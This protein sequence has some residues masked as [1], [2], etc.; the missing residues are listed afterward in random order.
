MTGIFPEGLF[1]REQ[2]GDGVVAG[3]GRGW[4]PHQHPSLVPAPRG[5]MPEPW[6]SAGSLPDGEDVSQAR[7]RPGRILPTASRTIPI[8]G[9]GRGQ[10]WGWQRSSLRWHPPCRPC[11]SPG[12]RRST[13][14]HHLKPCC[15][16]GSVGA[17]SNL[18]WFRDPLCSAETG[19]GEE[20]T[21][22]WGVLGGP[23]AGLAVAVQ[24]RAL[25]LG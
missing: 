20:E 14:R 15:P 21:F 12:T 8:V 3:P 6:L 16:V 10:G 1:W 18:G 4:G 17:G 13:L 25:H 11:C 22:G 9:W 7:S 23:W 19:K 24:G 2:L 5:E